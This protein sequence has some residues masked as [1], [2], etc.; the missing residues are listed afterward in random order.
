MRARS[1]EV[2]CTA[3]ILGIACA[4]PAVAH[5]A[6]TI[7]EPVVQAS[8]A[9]GSG[10]FPLGTSAARLRPRDPAVYRPVLTTS[11]FLR[12]DLIEDAELRRMTGHY[13]RA[14]VRDSA[15]NADAQNTGVQDPASGV[16]MN[17]VEGEGMWPSVTVL[18]HGDIEAEA[19]SAF[20]GGG[21]RP[22]VRSALDWRLT[23]DTSLAAMP[24][25]VYDK[26]NGQ[27][28]ASGMLGIALGRAWTPRLRTYVEAAAERIASSRHGGSTVT[29][30]LGGA[31]LLRD[32]VQ[33]D[34]SLSWGAGSD[35]ADLAWTVGLSLKF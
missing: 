30:N 3:L 26:T 17:V 7:E 10:H 15:A 27:R 9:V 32:A 25:I 5:E 33:I 28:H 23:S 8:T 18:V 35:T 12:L 20:Q 1:R 2:A 6:T 31:Y 4:A 16:K 29:Y 13:L 14:N 34:S 11:A 22:S 21:V 24:G 19:R